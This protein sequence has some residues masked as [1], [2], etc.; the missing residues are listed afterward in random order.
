SPLRETGRGSRPSAAAHPILSPYVARSHLATGFS[1]HPAARMSVFR[2]GR[3]RFRDPRPFAGG[4]P[5]LW[6]FPFFPR[7]RGTT[8][9]TR[10]VLVG[11]RPSAAVPSSWL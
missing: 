1:L 4:L 9:P 8:R 11:C 6:G 10:A 7:T 5:K 3:L 2:A